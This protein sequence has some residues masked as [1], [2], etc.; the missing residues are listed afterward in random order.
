MTLADIYDALLSKRIYKPAFGYEEAKEKIVSS[1]GERFDPVMTEVM[2]D[3]I[4]G[5]EEM[6]KKYKTFDE[7][8]D[9]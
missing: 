6:H 1:S 5:F 9:A 4:E 7:V 3:H 8:D 2:V